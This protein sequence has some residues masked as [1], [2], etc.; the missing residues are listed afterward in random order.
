MAKENQEAKG[1][2]RMLTREAFGKKGKFARRTKIVEV[3]ELNGLMG[4]EDPDVASIK[5]R[6]LSLTEYLVT[7]GEIANYAVNL[8]EGLLAAAVEKGTLKDEILELWNK[9]GQEE[10]YNI[11]IVEAGVEEPKLN[12]SDVVFIAKMFPLVLVR[13]CNQILELTNQGGELKKN[14][15][16]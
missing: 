6:Q 9:M 14:S 1:E 10:K 2:S 13:I 8:V 5:I 16:A 12:R 7:R 3:P 11:A 4:I 15:R